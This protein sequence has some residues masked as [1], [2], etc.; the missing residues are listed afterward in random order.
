M[1]IQSSPHLQGIVNRGFLETSSYDKTEN[2]GNWWEIWFC[3]LNWAYFSGTMMSTCILQQK[4][5]EVAA[6]SNSPHYESGWE[7]RILKFQHHSRG[8]ASTWLP[9]DPVWMRIRKQIY[10]YARYRGE[11]GLIWWSYFS[12]FF[13][14]DNF[15]VFYVFTVFLK[16]LR[17]W[18]KS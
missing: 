4:K 15:L 13:Y 9:C 17:K 11:N 1:V 7:A 6:N 12:V 18:R 5:R 8:V 2:T 14:F 16:L 3:H 10:S